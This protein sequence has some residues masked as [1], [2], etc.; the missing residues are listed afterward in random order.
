MKI[1]NNNVKNHRLN[2]E[3][4]NVLKSNQISVSQPKTNKQSKFLPW[5]TNTNC[6]FIFARIFNVLVLLNSVVP[7]VKIHTKFT[8]N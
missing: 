1:K 8:K 6:R 5:T 3:K 4:I 7:I 2:V